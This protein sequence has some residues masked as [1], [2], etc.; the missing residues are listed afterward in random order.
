MSKYG[1]MILGPAGAGKSTLCTAMIQ[2]L[3]HSRR[4]CYYVNLDPAASQFTYEPDIDIRDLISLEDVMEELDLGPNGGLIYCFEFLLDNLDFL[5]QPLE[6]ATE[7]YLI[8][9][10]MPGQIELY[11]HVPILPA[12]F[13][14][15]TRG[16]LN[17]NIC[18]AYLLEATF[19]VDHAKFFAGTLS[20][21]SAMLMLEVPHINVISK[22]DLVK[23][24]IGNEKI[25]QMLRPTL[26][27]L[28]GKGAND[29]QHTKELNCTDISQPDGEVSVNQSS[30]KVQTFHGLN[31]AVAELIE[32]FGMVDFL[33]LNAQNED[34]VE[35]ILS[36]IDNAIQYHEAQEPRELIGVASEDD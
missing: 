14:Y 31:K 2:H 16:T 24:T 34:S 17:M 8:V 15:L 30:M 1:V 13:K 10:D 28:D 19:I 20:A 27:L 35:A 25:K 3:H 22:I 23:D 32:Q 21:M 26:S 18:V 33:Q 7:E 29:D 36:H 6:L 9:F 12:L 5:T 4:S 11:T